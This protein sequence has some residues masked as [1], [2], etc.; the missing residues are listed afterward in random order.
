[1]VTTDELSNQIIILKAQEL[2]YKKALEDTHD[3]L[4]LSIG[5][6]QGYQECK[7]EFER[8]FDIPLTPEIEQRIQAIIRDVKAKVT[9]KRA[10]K[11]AKVDGQK[12][13]GTT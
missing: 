7:T 1:M 6:Q 8:K 9:K 11:K 10:P 13:E 4:M 2:T 12:L 3:N 5:R